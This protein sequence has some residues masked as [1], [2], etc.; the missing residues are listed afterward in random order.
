MIELGYLM[1]A[2]YVIDNAKAFPETTFAMVERC[3][4]LYLQLAQQLE[5]LMEIVPW[6]TLCMFPPPYGSFD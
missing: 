1:A 2:A 6:E 4:D 5:S 3:K